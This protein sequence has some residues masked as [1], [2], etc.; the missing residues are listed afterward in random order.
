[1]V[2]ILQLFLQIFKM[3]GILEWVWGVTFLLKTKRRLISIENKLVIICGKIVDSSKLRRLYIFDPN[4]TMKTQM[5]SIHGAATQSKENY[6]SD[7][8]FKPTMMIQHIMEFMVIF[9]VEII[10]NSRWKWGFIFSFSNL[11]NKRSEI[12]LSCNVLLYKRLASQKKPQIIQ[13][14]I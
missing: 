1:M 12:I 9:I 10:N 6:T 11:F 7:I 4:V 8:M 14:N 5:T 3:A 2:W 13:S